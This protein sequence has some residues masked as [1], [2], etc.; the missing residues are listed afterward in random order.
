MVYKYAARWS[1]SIFRLRTFIKGFWSISGFSIHFWICYT[2][3]PRKCSPR[4]CSFQKCSWNICHQK[5]SQ[6][7]IF[8][9]CS[10]EVAWLTDILRNFSKINKAELR[11]WVQKSKKALIHP[12]SSSLNWRNPSNPMKLWLFKLTKR[13]LTVKLV[14]FFNVKMNNYVLNFA[15]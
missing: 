3:R 14:P 8:R 9:N 5:T 1:I 6:A 15:N 12:N 11:K 7:F 4:K 13:K 2:P 10:W